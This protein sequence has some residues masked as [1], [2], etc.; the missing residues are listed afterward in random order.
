[1]EG[2]GMAGQIR[3]ART[4]PA[5]LPRGRAWAP[6]GFTAAEWSVLVGTYRRHFRQIDAEAAMAVAVAALHAYRTFGLIE[7]AVEREGAA[8]SMSPRTSWRAL[9]AGRWL[10]RK[11]RNGR[12]HNA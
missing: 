4:D 2:L 12:I 3:S 9:R 11:L 6:A 5:A 7:V 8:R 10:L 1:M